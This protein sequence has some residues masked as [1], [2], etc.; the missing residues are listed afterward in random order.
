MLNRMVIELVLSRVNP[1][2][3]T[4]HLWRNPKEKKQKTSK[5]ERH[6][7]EKPVRRWVIDWS[8]LWQVGLDT[9]EIMGDTMKTIPHNC[10]LRKEKEEHLSSASS[11]PL[12]KNCSWDTNPFTLASCRCMPATDT[13]IGVS[14]HGVRKIL[15]RQWKCVGQWSQCLYPWEAA[16]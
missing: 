2:K 5:S 1:G 14:S 16:C 12:L 3:Q 6:R 9:I 15:D 11:S 4:I 8:P 10:S 13:S 7:E